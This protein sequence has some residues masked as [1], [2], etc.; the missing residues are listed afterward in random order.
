LS[1]H[2]FWGIAE[3]TDKMEFD[4][5]H[6]SPTLWAD[7]VQKAVQIVGVNERKGIFAVVDWNHFIV[8]LFTASGESENFSSISF[9]S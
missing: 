2:G 6:P 8:Q 9:T 7:H 1:F 4:A 5:T 3:A